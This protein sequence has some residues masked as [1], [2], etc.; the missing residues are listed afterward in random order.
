MIDKLRALKDK[1]Q[2]LEEQLSDPEVTSDMNRFM[3]INKEYKDLKPLVEAHDSYKAMLDGIAEC[4]EII[5]EG[6]DPDFVEMAK[7]DL[8]EWE[9]KKG[10]F[11]EELKMMLIPKDPEDEKNVTIEIRAGAGGD[12]AAIFAGDMLRVYERFIDKQG[13]KRE[14]IASNESESGGFSKVILE[15]TGDNVY[16]MLKYESGTHRVQRIPK[17]ESQGRV[18]TSAVTVAVMPIFEMED[19]EINKADLSWDTFRASG[20]GGQHVNKTE[21]AV[22]VT[23]KPSGVV[24]E[25]QD[26]RSQLK[27][28]EIALQ[29]LYAKL[30]ELQQQEHEDSISALRNTLIVSGDRSSKIRTYN[31]SQNRVTDHRINFTKYNLSEVMDGA[32]D[33]FIE[34]I[35][36][37]YNM[38][39]LKAS[40][41]V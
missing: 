1:F 9:D 13:W 23:H 37:T 14:Y 28:R 8:K 41:E 18:H 22:R 11:E 29:K 35:Q 36:V 5:A 25:C 34:A 3:K 30:Y 4:K 40:E 21:S 26:G 16:G 10:P 7:E 19:V 38:E 6:G 12:E 33:E 2:L 32:L 39:K 17:T 31:Y 15:V 24:V 27:N 20:A